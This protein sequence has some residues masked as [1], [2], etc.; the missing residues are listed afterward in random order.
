MQ[1]NNSVSLETVNTIKEVLSFAAKRKKAS[2][3]KALERH[4]TALLHQP[5]VVRRN[6]PSPVVNGSPNEM[7]TPGAPHKHNRIVD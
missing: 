1:K 5:T 3:M 2:I 7:A 6:S 4:L